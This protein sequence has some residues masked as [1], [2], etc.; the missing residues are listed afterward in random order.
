MSGQSCDELR[1]VA[2][3]LASGV[4]S[5]SA[6]ADALGHLDHCAGCRASVE[7]L[8]EAADWLLLAA[9]EG[10]PPIGFESRVFPTLIDPSPARPNAHAPAPARSATPIR[11]LR[12]RRAVVGLAAATTVVVG[13]TVA[14][15]T[16]LETGTNGASH[17]SVADTTSLRSGR[18][19]GVDG[20]PVGQ[21]QTYSGSPGWVFMNVDASGVGGT[22]VCQLQM[23]NGKTVPLGA[24]DVHDGVGEWAHTVAGDVGQFRGAK[25]VTPSGAALATATFA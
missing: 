21:V 16:M 20:R 19:L 23:A 13:G 1:E 17:Q 18:F 24:F 7:E 11:A 22:V 6:R 2:G 5:G 8:S 14:T 3:E 10:D 4:L 15:T 12:W 25:L 9:P